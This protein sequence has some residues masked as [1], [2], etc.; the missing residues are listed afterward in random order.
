M[1]EQ[2]WLAISRSNL[3]SEHVLNY[4]TSSQAHARVICL[5]TAQ[6]LLSCVKQGPDGSE[7]TNDS[8]PLYTR[9]TKNLASALSS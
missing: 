6:V 9:D 7:D 5:V 4:R 3:D 1:D 8:P 2:M